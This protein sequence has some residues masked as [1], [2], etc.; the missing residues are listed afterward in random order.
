M[1][2]ISDE[3]VRLA[4]QRGEEELAFWTAHYEEFLATYPNQFIAI[5]NKRVVASHTD[6]LTLITLLE[7]QGLQPSDVWLRYVDA[8]LELWSL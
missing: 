4:R 1:T 8:D 7:Q 5:L 3:A 2:S 6:L